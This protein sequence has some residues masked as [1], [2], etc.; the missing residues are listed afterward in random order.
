MTPIRKLSQRSRG[1]PAELRRRPLGGVARPPSSSTC[2]TRRSARSSRRRRCRRG[3]ISTRRS[4][5]GAKAFPAWRDTPVVQ[6]AR[7]DVPVRAAARAALRGDRAHRHDR[8]RQDARR[9]A[10]QR[11]PRHRVRRGRVRRAVADDGLRARGHRRR[12]RLPRRPPAARRRRRDRAVQLPGDGAAVVPA[13]RRSSPATRSS[14]KPSEQV[15]LSQRMMF[16]LLEQCDLP[17]GVVNLV[18]GGREVVDAICDHPG[19]RAVSFV[20]STPVARARLPAR[21]ARRQARPGARRRQELRRRDAGRRLRRV[22][23][24]SSP[25]RSTAAP[26]SA[27]SPAACCVP[28]GDA[29]TRGARPPGRGGAQPEGRRRHAS[30]A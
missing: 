22:D 14:L 23:R 10:R 1:N 24:R 2:T 21:H 4:G 15:P 29:H 26:A 27:A 28:V 8:A 13:V 9:V 30:P 20:G 11:P 18:N 7:D 19:I 5:R 17:P 3:P 16:E 6:R 25:S 12:H